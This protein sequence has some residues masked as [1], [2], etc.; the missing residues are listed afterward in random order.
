MAKTAGGEGAAP[1]P[2]HTP[3]D[4]ERQTVNPLTQSDSTNEPGQEGQRSNDGEIHA[5][6][7]AE[8]NSNAENHQPASAS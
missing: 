4:S 1:P 2:K 3:I 7:Q 6:Q 8:T 5:K